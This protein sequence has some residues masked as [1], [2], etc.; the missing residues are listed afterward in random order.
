MIQ[1]LGSD[2][3]ERADVRIISASTLG[4]E[5]LKKSLY[6]PLFYRIEGIELSIQPLRERGTEE[7]IYYFLFKEC[8][9]LRKEMDI[10]EPAME[11][12]RRYQWPGNLRE[13]RKVIH[14][15][16]L[17]SK[18]RKIEIDDLPE[19]IRNAEKTPFIPPELIASLSEK[20]LSINSILSFSQKEQ[21]DELTLNNAIR[22]HIQKVLAFTKG[23]KSKAAKLLGIPL[24]TLISKMKKLG[25]E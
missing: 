24:T 19:K 15:A 7:Y 12:L 1:P 2:R 23:N 9:R 10:S 16:V 21:M 5:D 17:L 18:G 3:I 20:S 14:R 25:I 4:L 8:K 13:I 11:A 22:M 6:P